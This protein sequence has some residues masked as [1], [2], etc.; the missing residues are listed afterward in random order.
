MVASEGLFR[1]SCDCVGLPLQLLRAVPQLLRLL[2][3]LES[4]LVQLESR[5]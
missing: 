3:Q 2:V 5:V 4:L 1:S